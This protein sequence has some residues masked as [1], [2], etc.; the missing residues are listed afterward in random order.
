MGREP[1]V[2]PMMVA[3]GLAEP[4]AEDSTATAEATLPD[5]LK[6]DSSKTDAVKRQSDSSGTATPRVRVRP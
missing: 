6:T 1:Q 4:P 2:L 3:R 5:S